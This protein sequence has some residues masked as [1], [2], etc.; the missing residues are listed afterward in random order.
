MLFVGLSLARER[1]ASEGGPYKEIQTGTKKGA[2]GTCPSN[3]DIDADE[4]GFFSDVDLDLGG[5][6]AE[7]FDGYR[8]LT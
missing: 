4:L 3:N 5:D 8:E 1:P 7:N 2:R 6:V